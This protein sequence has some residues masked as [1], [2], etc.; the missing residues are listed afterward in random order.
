MRFTHPTAAPAKSFSDGTRRVPTTLHTEMPA[1]NDS[2]FAAHPRD[3]KSNLYV[4][5]VLSRRA[6]G[7]SIGV[8]LNRNKFCNFHC[9]YCQVALSEPGADDLVDLERLRQELDWTVELVT[10]GRIFAEGQFSG[11]PAAAE[12]AERHRLFRR[13]RADGLSQFRRGRGRV[14]R[15]P[16]PPPT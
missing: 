8:N 14:R 11:T 9:V 16:R 10:S 7:I 13:R 4:Y 5:P 15:S 2:P 12:A 6:G 1:S 3:F